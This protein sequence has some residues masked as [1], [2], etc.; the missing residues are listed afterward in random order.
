MAEENTPIDPADDTVIGEVENAVPAGT[1]VTPVD[2]TLVMDPIPSEEVAATPSLDESGAVV[3][4]SGAASRRTILW[5]IVAVAVVVL[6]IGLAYA[7]ARND[8]SRGTGDSTALEGSHRGTST[9]DPIPS[10]PSAS[11]TRTPSSPV[12]VPPGQ[13]APTASGS[14]PSVAPIGRPTEPAPEGSKLTT[15]T[16][17]PEATLA[18]V[19]PTKLK[20]DARYSLVFSPYG[21]GPSRGGQPSLVIRISTATPTNESAKAL[22]LSDRNL[23][24]TAMPGQNPVTLGGTYTGVLT[25]RPDGGLLIPVISEVKPKE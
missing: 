16:Q 23:L 3:G 18:M 12:P 4:T 10:A 9:V 24:A 14:S 8:P 19:E 20:E 7:T 1:D 11:G 17:P 6:I 25:F 5:T 21:Y 2:D 22:D 15:V 13:T